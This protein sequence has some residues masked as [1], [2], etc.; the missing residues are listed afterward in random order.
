MNAYAMVVVPSA[1]PLPDQYGRDG[2]AG[3]GPAFPQP[4]STVDR[5]I[6]SRLPAIRKEWIAAFKTRY[7]QDLWGDGQNGFVSARRIRSL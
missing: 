7:P 5:F 3:Q 2:D 6:V 4:E 1:P